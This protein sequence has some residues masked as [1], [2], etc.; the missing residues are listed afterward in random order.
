[1]DSYTWGDEYS[2]EFAQGVPYE[3]QLELSNKLDKDMWTNIPHRASDDFVRQLAQMIRDNL[4]DGLHVWVEYTNEHWNYWF[5]QNDWMYQQSQNYTGDH[6]YEEYTMHHYFGKRAGEVCEIFHEEFVDDSRIKCVLSGQSGYAPPLE[7]AAEEVDRLGY[8]D[9]FSAVAIAP[10]WGNNEQEALTQAMKDAMPEPSE[11]DF[12][13]IFDELYGV[14]DQ[15]FDPTAEYG[16]NMIANKKVADDRDW[17][18]V[19]YEAGQHIVSWHDETLEDLPL[20]INERPEMYDLYLEY[21]NGWNE[22]TDGS[23][24]VMFHLAGAWFGGE[25]FGHLKDYNQP[26]EEAHKYRALLNWLK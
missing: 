19:T 14:V 1:M 20:L 9:L 4:D 8:T 18:F 17:D 24:I 21:L 5:P 15:I 3:I 26:I 10:Y 12:K 23:Q 7:L 22:F 6:P 2:P 16:E 13:K 11:S 25:C